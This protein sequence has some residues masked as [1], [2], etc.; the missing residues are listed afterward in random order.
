MNGLIALRVS[1]FN[2][3]HDLYIFN[4]S[5]IDIKKQSFAFDRIEF[6]NNHL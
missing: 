1:P 3:F 2:C 5:I 4:D 6:G